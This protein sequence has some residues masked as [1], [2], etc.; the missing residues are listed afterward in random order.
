MLVSGAIG[1]PIHIQRH[2]SALGRWLI[3]RWRPR[4]LAGVL[5]HLWYFEGTVLHPR[6]RIFPDGRIELNV[7]FGPR[8]GEVTGNRV[9]RFSEAVLSGLLLRPTIIEAPPG[10]SAVLGVRMLPTGAFALLGGPIH[11][12]TGTTVD[13]AELVGYAAEALAARCE[14]AE[15]LAWRGPLPDV[16]RIDV[17]PAGEP[18]VGE[19][20]GAAPLDAA[21]RGGRGTAI[22][23]EDPAASRA[24][25]RLALA[26]EWIAERVA[27][28]PAVDPAIAWAAASIERSGGTVSISALRERAGWSKSR[29]STL[30][31]EQVGVSP[32]RLARVVRF[33]RALDLV[34]HHEL[35]LSRV[36]HAAGYYDQPHLNAEFREFAGLSPGELRAA[37]R[38]PASVNVAEPAR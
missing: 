31:R 3:A 4:P 28:G 19:A 17:G 29:F 33:R 30:F 38:Y 11:E 32:K 36:A 7:H 37:R 34:V 16:I 9:E 8:Y 24:V 13:L 35:P 10:P 23:E 14:A 6:E 2:D 22:L 5:D 12:L 15:R 20:S 25:R 27:H 26:G 1:T 21:P 18:G